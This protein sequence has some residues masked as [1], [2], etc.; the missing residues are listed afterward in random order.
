MVDNSMLAK[1]ILK[2]N[3]DILHRFL[4]IF[5]RNIVKIECIE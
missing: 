4:E 1:K 3:N 5:Y 2:N